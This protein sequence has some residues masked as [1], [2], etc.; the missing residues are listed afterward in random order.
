MPDFRD[1]WMTALLY[2]GGYE[3]SAVGVQP[4]EIGW[5]PYLTVTPRK[6]IAT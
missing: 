4:I 6:K 1:R 3:F 2:V 5:T